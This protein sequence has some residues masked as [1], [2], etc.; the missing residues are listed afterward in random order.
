MKMGGLLQGTLVL[1]G[2]GMNL[3]EATEETKTLQKILGVPNE[4]GKPSSEA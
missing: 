4:V 2:R 1:T 3:E